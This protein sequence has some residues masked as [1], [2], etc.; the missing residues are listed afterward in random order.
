M[1]KL[2]P[3]LHQELRLAIVSFL[4]TVEAADFKKLTEVTGASKGNL[5]VQITKLQTAK[6]IDVTKSFKG[7][8][9][10]TEC[11]LTDQGKKEYAEYIKELKQMLKL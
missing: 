6:Y 11:S 1:G 4:A 5:S 10:H 3:L 2:N 7:N 9:P 8:Y